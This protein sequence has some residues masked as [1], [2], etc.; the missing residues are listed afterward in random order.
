MT[1]TYKFSILSGMPGY[2]P[3]YIGGPYSAST[4]RELVNI[5]RNELDMLDYPAN[6]FADFNVRQMWRFIQVA[7]SGSSCHSSCDSHKGEVLSLHGL[8]DAEADEMEHEQD[9]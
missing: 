1:I 4:R 6:R 2:M 8:T 5:I 7:C 3:N 9:Y